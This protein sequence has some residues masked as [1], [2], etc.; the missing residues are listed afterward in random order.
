MAMAGAGLALNAN[1]P[2]ESLRISNV[3]VP[4]TLGINNPN[5]LQTVPNWSTGG[6]KNSPA[7]DWFENGQIMGLSLM[8]AAVIG[9][10]AILIFRKK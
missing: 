5:P 2:A 4:S 3:G 1:R 8:T 10:A 9:V 6:R 7:V